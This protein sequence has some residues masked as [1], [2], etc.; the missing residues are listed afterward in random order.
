MTLPEVAVLELAAPS[1]ANPWRS[2]AFTVGPSAPAGTGWVGHVDLDWTVLL[3]ARDEL[4]GRVVAADGRVLLRFTAPSLADGGG[5]GTFGR[6]RPADGGSVHLKA[7]A[8]WWSALEVPA[9]A[10]NF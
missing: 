8:G 9:P 4:S 3:G 7:G 5:P 1:A 2:R 6:L 10:V